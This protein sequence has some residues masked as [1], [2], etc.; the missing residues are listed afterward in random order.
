MLRNLLNKI[1]CAQTEFIIIRCYQFAFD[2]ISSQPKLNNESG[3]LGTTACRM[4]R[5]GNL[6]LLTFQITRSRSVELGFIFS[7]YFKV[8]STIWRWL[9]KL[10]TFQIELNPL[11]TIAVCCPQCFIFHLVQF[12]LI[13]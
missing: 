4:V 13:R 10:Q 7:F 11:C 12:S 9:P 8:K 1:L 5:K 2:S 3:L 6:T